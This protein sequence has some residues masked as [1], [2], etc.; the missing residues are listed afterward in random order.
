MKIIEALRKIEQIR[1]PESAPEV[2]ETAAHEL[3]TRVC[4]DARIIR[5]AEPGE[6]GDT[7]SGDRAG[8]F[9]MAPASQ[10]LSG[11][12]GKTEPEESGAVY[13][14]IRDQGGGWLA[15]DRPYLLF[16]FLSHLI[17]SLRDRPLDESLVRGKVFTPSFAWHR[18]SYDYFLTQ[19]G[20]IQKGL[21][22]ASYVRELARLGFTHIEVNALATPMG[23][24]GGPK[25]EAYPMFYTYC[26]ALDQ[27]VSSKLN[28]GIYP[29]YYLSANLQA[30]KTNA[31]LAREY[32]LTPGLLCFEPRS[33]PES[34]F[35]RY[36]ML[37]GARVDH[38]MRSFKP[39]YN[40]TIVH[41]AVRDHYAEMMENLMREVPELGYLCLWTNDSGAGFE[42]TQSLYVG[43]N[44]GPY[45]IREWKNHDE[46]SRC[47]GENALR[48]MRVLREAGRKTNPSF[49]VL[50]RLESFYGEHETIWA[51]LGDGLDVETASLVARGWDMPYS[52]PRYADSKAINAGTLYHQA[53]SDAEKPFIEAI[54][55]KGG[56][57]H[58]YFTAGP[59]WIFEPLLGIPYP[60]LTLKRLRTLHRGGVKY[61]AHSGG[62]CPPEAVPFNV[63]HEAARLFA[64][65]A[66]LDIDD[67][68]KVIAEKRVKSALAQKLVDAWGL[69]EEAMLAFPNITS[70][71]SAFG[72]TWYR[73]WVRPLVPNIEAL[74]REERAYYED[75]MCTM[76][77][78]PNNVDLSRDVLFELTTPEKS[79][80]DIR[81]IDENLWAPMDKAIGILQN[82][83][84]DDE[85][86]SREYS[87][88]YDQWVRLRALRTWFMTQRNVAAWI[89][90]V[91]GFLRA[92]SDE[93]RKECRNLLEEMAEKEIQNMSDLLELLE[94]GVSFMAFTDQGETPLVHGDNL[95]ELLPV[96]MKLMRD[97]IH[98]TPF[99]DAGYMERKAV[100]LL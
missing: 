12:P 36:P 65:D 22:R 2:Y 19:E 42:H 74:S 33:V 9:R 82:V 92:S 45:L 46:I 8:L 56:R 94:T 40:M 66:D 67:A 10:G 70:L 75:F 1:I 52:H 30:L 79:R 39:R 31:A 25:G 89:A 15:T 72:F 16:G 64:F 61:L 17:E 76:P 77:H 73:L 91:H 88:F 80:I 11:K 95:K 78:N 51:G 34:F 21:D 85:L 84:D 97:H 38:P 49:R 100:E 53:F 69:A 62:T 63:N 57:A 68:V 59:H 18:V 83:L 98:D 41:P 37:R 26:A 81:R 43:R 6:S 55:E 47:A 50:T 60:S 5:G 29:H 48:F 35:D 23:M 3:K 58:F 99:I 7:A 54:H 32:G 86:S 14:Q 20:R 27:F 44:G 71:Y 87:V 4:P 96:R 13:L 28:K 90:G 93:G 24:E